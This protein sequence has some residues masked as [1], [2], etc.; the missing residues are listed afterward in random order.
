MFGMVDEESKININTQDRLVLERLFEAVLPLTPSEC[1]ELAENILRWRGE[2]ED[3]TSRDDEEYYAHLEFPYRPKQAPFEMREEL[4]LVRGMTEEIY[5]QLIP[6]ITVYGDG[7]VN[8]NTAT[9][10]VL[11]A[12]GLTE[13]TIKKILEVRRG[14]D[15]LE[16]T[17]DDFIFLKTFDIVSD[18]EQFVELRKEEIK[19]IDDLNAADKLKTNSYLYLI[20]S[21]AQLS[22][23]PLRLMAQCVYNLRENKIEYFREN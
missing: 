4:L 1:H 17:P 2:G 22:Y 11:N 15:G 10:V 19:E 16:A 23:A 3:R 18:L 8:I 20:Q 13:D 7:G 6:Y 21:S 14:L 9:V 12:L 5:D